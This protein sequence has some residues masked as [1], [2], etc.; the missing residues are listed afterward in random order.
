M[1]DMTSQE[2]FDSETD[3]GQGSCELNSSVQMSEK[4]ASSGDDGGL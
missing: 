1:Q 4:T 2:T 3:S